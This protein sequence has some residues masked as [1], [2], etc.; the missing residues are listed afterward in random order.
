M[1]ERKNKMSDKLQVAK[2]I[3]QQLGGNKFK[4]MVGGEN[5]GGTENSLSFRFK[6]CKK[7]T[8]CKIILNSTD[9]YTVNFYKITKKTRD[10]SP[11]KTYDM[12]YNDQLEDIFKEFTGLNTRL[13]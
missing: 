4:C 9:L 13:F 8:H 7:A 10:L 1:I 6:M 12:I 3:Y 5:F 11:V 2:T